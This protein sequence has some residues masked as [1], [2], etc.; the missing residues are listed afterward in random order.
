MRPISMATKYF[1][2]KLL[3]ENAIFIQDEKQAIQLLPAV[4]ML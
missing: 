2:A 1:H 3:I 4:Q